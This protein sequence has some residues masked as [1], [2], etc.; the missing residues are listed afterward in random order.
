MTQPV[1]KTLAEVAAELRTVVAT[2]HDK[3]GPQYVKI[4]ALAEQLHPIPKAETDFT[5][6]AQPSYQGTHKR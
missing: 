2:W 5:E 3:D 4:M 6:P 1:L